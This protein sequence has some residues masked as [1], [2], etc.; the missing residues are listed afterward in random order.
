MSASKCSMISWRLMSLCG[1]ANHGG[2]I[3]PDG[4]PLTVLSP[5]R[6]G[7]SSILLPKQE[8]NHEPNRILHVSPPLEAGC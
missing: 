7:E 8:H 3:A 1:S 4:E 5:E 6:D 2:R